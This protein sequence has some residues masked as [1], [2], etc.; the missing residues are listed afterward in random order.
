MKQFLFYTFFVFGLAY[1]FAQLQADN[2]LLARF[3][4][5]KLTQLELAQSAELKFWNYYVDN[6]FKVLEVGIKTAEY[7]SL[8]NIPAIN[9][10]TGTS[11]DVSNEDPANPSF[12][13]LKFDVPIELGE[14]RIYK[15]DNNRIIVFYSKRTFVDL[16]NQSL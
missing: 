8:Y 4:Q 10:I 5:T 2:R 11:F 9:P 3:S 7:T 13:P 1:S 16:F 14:E 12:N 6:S 15:L